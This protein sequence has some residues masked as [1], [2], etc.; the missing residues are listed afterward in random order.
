MSGD[1]DAK[2]FGTG[3]VICTDEKNK[4]I[5]TYGDDRNYV[6]SAQFSSEVTER[7]VSVSSKNNLDPVSAKAVSSVAA[8]AENPAGATS[9]GRDFE[10]QVIKKINGET[11]ILIGNEDQ[12]RAIGTD[13][14]VFTAV[15]QTDWTGT[16]HVLDMQDGRRIQLYGGDADLLST[17]NGYRDYNFHH[18]N[19]LVKPNSLATRYYVGVNQETGKPY[20]D[21]T[22]ATTD[23]N[24]LTEASWRTGEKYTTTA[25]YIIFRDIGLGGQSDPW[26]PLMF[27]GTMYGA[28]SAN[29]ETLWN[30]SNI[31]DSTKL[32]A[33]A[34]ANRPK[35]KNVYVR[36]D[37]AV[38]VNTY[39][40]VGFFATISNQPNSNDI[41]LSGGT[42][43]VKNI[44]L[45][46]VHVEN[47]TTQQIKNVD[48]SLINKVTTGLGSAV[49]AVL[50]YLLELLSV[51]SIPH[52][53]LNGTL[54]NLLNARPD[55]P[56]ALATGAFAGRIYGDV[57]VED[58]RVSG[59]VNVSS[60]NDRVGGFV[61][62]TEGMTQYDGL[63]EAL[64]GVSALLAGVLNII[65]AIGL[66][67]LITILLDNGLEVGKLI[68]TGY[69]EPKI[70]SC[71]VNGL[72]GVIGHLNPET[73]AA[74]KEFIGGFV[75]E[76]I[77]TRI[78]TSTVTNSSFT[79]KA[80]KF[81]GGF[82][83]LA[84]DAVIMGTLDGLGLDLTPTILEKLNTTLSQTHP[85]S[86]L[87]DCVVS[88]WEP[89]ENETHNVTGEDML[90]G[91]V[92][93]MANSYAVDCSV[94]CQVYPIKINAAG[95]DAGGFA[96]YASVGW[97]SSL[98][99]ANENSSSLLGTVGKLV[100]SLISSNPSEGQMLLSLMGVSPSAIIGCS[101]YSSGLEV[102]AGNS[103]A[104]GLLG[105]GDAVYIGTS[106][107]AAYDTLAEW[108]SGM[109]KEAVEQDDKPVII[110]GLKSVTA[111]QNCAGG[112]AGYIDSAQFQGLLN[113][114][115]GLGDFIGFSVRDIEVTGIDGG[116]T[117]TAGNYNAGGGFGLAVGGTI[118][119][120]NLKELKRVQAKNRAAG[121]VG[122]AGPGELL[123]TGGLTINLL[124][125][126]RLLSA[127]NLLNIGQGVQVT[128]SGCNVIGIADGFEVEATGV[129]PSGADGLRIYRCRLHRRQ[130]Q[131]RHFKL[132]R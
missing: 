24:S 113:N 117:V 17:Q 56:T 52:E 44:D 109:L 93:T 115:A 28:E 51:G 1:A 114:V 112:V 116:Y 87:I 66:G 111:Q 40:G 41:G 89:A 14:D 99:D 76:Q 128:I 58:C 127:N 29:G 92:G 5:L 120:V 30:G 108:N 95:S 126:D 4:H 3:K 72:T 20:T 49:T 55:D 74:D 86:V 79:V 67:D 70:V 75:G 73:S 110:G 105:R 39:I 62:Y 97:Q 81:G 21:A 132:S 96:G 25:N 42:A 106:D 100:T 107:K 77:G 78:Q 27:S 85:Q 23:Q 121:F 60:V 8:K 32:T 103:F 69:K 6:V 119:D 7:P 45:N 33:T 26:T 35:I 34:L 131:H 68:P 22:H 47:N 57:L 11:Y 90:G 124:G 13:A 53:T 82:C 122:V 88:D 54:E 18:I 46:G 130:Q 83:G 38:N 10:G 12:L 84:R 91:F 65:P 15:Y 63:S 9:D 61:G 129:N 118:D 101:V 37:T 31:T 64:S 36:Q 123:G 80:K 48:T 102:T 125:L 2:T 104:G 16:H 59:T 98:G 19:D 43:I 94:D 50:G 71:E